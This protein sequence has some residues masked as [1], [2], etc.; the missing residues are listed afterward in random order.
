MK[1]E[2][3]LDLSPCRSWSI[4]SSDTTGVLL[5]NS[6]K[7]VEVDDTSSQRENTFPWFATTCQLY[8]LV[9]DRVSCTC[10]IDKLMSKF[11]WTKNIFFTL[12]K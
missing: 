12:Y 11:L 9:F 3:G 8:S 6:L 5:R 1:Q 10:Y 2:H 7:L 4:I